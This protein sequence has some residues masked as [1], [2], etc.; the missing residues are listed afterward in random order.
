VAGATPT[1]QSPRW[2]APR[3]RAARPGGDGDDIIIGG[4]GVDPIDGGAG[5]DLLIGGTTS[6]DNSDS[7]LRKLRS[8]WL[9]SLRGIERL[10]D[11]GKTDELSGFAQDDG[12][13]DVD[14]ASA[15]DRVLR[16]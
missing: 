1:R 9:Q 14:V 3:G 4:L 6:H 8:L 10:T 7:D 11:R 15:R 5:D 16:S 13:A 12:A 2:S